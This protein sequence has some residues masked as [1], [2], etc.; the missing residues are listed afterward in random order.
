V[1]RSLVLAWLSFAHVRTE[2][3]LSFPWRTLGRALAAAAVAAWLA[4]RV[5]GTGWA[6]LGQLALLAGSYAILLRF[7]GESVKIQN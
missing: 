6:V 4:T 3:S 7:L 2:L 5:P 1:V